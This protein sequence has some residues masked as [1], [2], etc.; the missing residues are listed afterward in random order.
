[1]TT[2]RGVVTSVDGTLTEIESF[3]VLADG[4]VYTLVPAPDGD[5]AFPLPHLRDHLRT[6]EPVVV[7]VSRTADG[8]YVASALGDG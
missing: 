5:F 3:D 8:A 6:G 4:S 1:M 2:L 7:E